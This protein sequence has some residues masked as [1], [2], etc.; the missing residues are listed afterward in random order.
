MT[1]LGFPFIYTVYD[2]S[3]TKNNDYYIIEYSYILKF[4]SENIFLSVA[5]NTREYSAL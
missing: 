3:L 4:Y 1:V 2:K 5:I